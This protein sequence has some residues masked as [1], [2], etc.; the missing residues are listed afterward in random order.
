LGAALAAYHL[1]LGKPR[2]HTVLDGMSGSLLGPEFG[3]EEIEDLLR[4]AG[5]RNHVLDE[6]AMQSA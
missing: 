2:A 3:E 1:Y 6:Q 4:A 5:A